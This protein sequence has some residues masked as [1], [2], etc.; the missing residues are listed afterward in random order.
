MRKSWYR[1]RFE[2]DGINLNELTQHR[3]GI[4]MHVEFDN[5]TPFPID[6]ASDFL[7]WSENKQKFYPYLVE[8]ILQKYHFHDKIVIPIKKMKKL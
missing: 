4:R 7:R 3:R 2:P 1:N 8:L 6:S 5:N